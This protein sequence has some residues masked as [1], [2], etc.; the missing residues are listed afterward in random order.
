MWFNGL[1]AIL[2]VVFFTLF[3]LAF[4]SIVLCTERWFRVSHSLFFIRTLFTHIF[5]MISI[6]LFVLLHFW[7]RFGLVSLFFSLSL[8]LSIL[9][10][11][12]LFQ[13]DFRIVCVQ[14]NFTT[15]TIVNKRRENY[16][17]RCTRTL[18]MY[19]GAFLWAMLLCD[20]YLPPNHMEWDTWPKRSNRQQRN[21]P[22]MFKRYA[23]IKFTQ[24]KLSLLWDFQLQTIVN[25]AVCIFFSHIS[26]YYVCFTFFRCCCCRCCSFCTWKLLSRK[27][28]TAKMLETQSN[29]YKNNNEKL[30]QRLALCVAANVEPLPNSI[31]SNRSGTI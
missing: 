5:V 6:E 20:C 1:T 7:F 11:P 24:N 15:F 18:Y 29:L 30:L 13:L 9:S 3:C 8:S 2:H 10:L 31:D 4:V 26:F 14:C 12:S 17:D 19:H 25:A 21:K 27:Q 23:K 22:M 16:I 28:R